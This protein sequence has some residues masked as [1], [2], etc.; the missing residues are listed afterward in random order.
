MKIYIIVGELSGEKHASHLIR[1]LKSENKSIQIRGCGGALMKAAGCEI[2]FE[3]SDYAI[4]GFTKVIAN[5]SKIKKYLKDVEEDI[6]RFAPDKVIMIDYPG[7]N[8]RLAKN[9]HQI[10]PLYYYIPPKAW[11]WNKKRVHKLKKYYKKVYSI[12]PFEIDFFKKYK[13]PIQYVGN[14]SFHEVDNFLNTK[15]EVT[16]DYIALIPGSRAQEIKRM[17]PVMIDAANKIGKPYYISKSPNLKIDMYSEYISDTTILKED[18]YELLHQAEFALVTSGTA[19]LEAA[20]FD[21]PQIVCYKTDSFSYWIA[22]NLVSI[23]YISLVNLINDKLTITEL[24]Q[25]NCKSSTIVN[26]YNN[27]QDLSKRSKLQKEYRQMTNRLGTLNPSKF[28]AKDI[29]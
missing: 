3:Y 9:I 26:E 23:K 15:K 25:D 10:F 14:P 29:M 11:A 24:I 2:S 20:L 13:I 5:L 6:L 28:I 21:V 4:M 12:L 16:K 18:M 19:T 7:F 8:L 17:L 27:L 22:R 1:A